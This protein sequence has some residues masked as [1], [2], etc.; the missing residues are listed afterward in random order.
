MFLQQPWMFLQPQ[1]DNDHDD[2]DDDDDDGYDDDDGDDDEDD[3]DGDDDD[4]NDD[5]DEDVD[6]QTRSPPPRKKNEQ[7]RWRS[8]PR[9][10]RHNSGSDFWHKFFQGH[11]QA[12]H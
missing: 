12:Y 7:D 5:D 3:D 8:D 11:H 10:G 2:G 9:P 4:G 6:E 1:T